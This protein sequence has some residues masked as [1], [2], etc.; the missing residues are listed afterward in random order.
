MLTENKNGVYD[1]LRIEKDHAIV[2]RTS[3]SKIFILANGKFIE[4]IPSK[5]E[6]Y[7]HEGVE[8]KSHKTKLKRFVNP[9]L[10]KIQFFTDRPWVI[11]SQFLIIDS[12]YYLV[13]YSFERVLYHKC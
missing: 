4:K 11:A 1:V 12:D 6:S 10:R 13:G 9:I 7:F 5:V 3:D 2:S 8:Y